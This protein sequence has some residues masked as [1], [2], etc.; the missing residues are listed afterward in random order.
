M[1]FQSLL[2]HFSIALA[3]CSTLPA[4]PGV[5][6]GQTPPESIEA[7]IT[8]VQAL[9]KEGK[10]AAAA[11]LGGSW[12]ARYS[13]RPEANSASGARLWNAIADDYL[14][15]GQRDKCVQ[16]QLRALAIHEKIQ[17]PDHPDTVASLVKLSLTYDVLGLHEKALPLQ[18]RVLTVEE[19]L[20]GLEHSTTA[21]GLRALAF[22]YSA[23][24]QHDKAIPLRQRALAISEKTLGSEHFETAN[25]LERLAISYSFLSQ[26][27]K[28]LPLQLR[29]VAILEKVLGPEHSDTADFLNHLAFTYVA[30]GQYDKVLP[31]HQRALAIREKNHSL[32]HPT[33]S[34][35]LNNLADTYIALVQYDKALPLQLRALATSEKVLGLEHLDTARSLNNLADTY[36]A[37]AQYDKALPLQLR[38]LSIREKI[39]GTEH[40]DTA[41]SLNNLAITY[42]AQAQYDKALPLQLRTQAIYGK[43]LGPS[44]PNTATSLNNLAETYSAL[45]QYEK[46]LPL[47]LHALAINEKALGSEHPDTALILNNLAG[48]YYALAQYEK[49]LPLQL[50]ALAINEK[51]LGP[52][53]PQ[54]AQSLGNLA[55][56]YNALAQ[57]D[58]VLPLQL[59]ALAIVEKVLGPEHPNTA[60]SL[61]NL[62]QTYNALAQYDEALP[63]QLRA[64][65][66][67]EKV[68][69]P[70]HP[71]TAFNWGNLAGIVEAMEHNSAAVSFLKR[72]VN[73]YQRQREQVSII[74]K[75]AL[76]SYTDLVGPNYKALARLL[77]KE[78]RLSEAQQV[79]DMLKE[80]EQFDFVRRNATADPRHTRVGYTATEQKW[81]DRYQQISAQLVAL[82]V[83]ERELA[84]AEKPGLN[85]TQLARQ[86]VLKADLTVARKAFD[87]YIA[88][89]QT[90]FST[91]GAAR[92]VEVAETSVQA[93]RDLQALI[94]SL[95]EGV[96]L[97]QYYVTNNQ[98]NM[99]LTTPGVQKA[100]S[101]KVDTKELN[102]QIAAFGG[103]LRDHKSDPLP[104]AQALYR[105]LLAPV[106]ADL[107]QAGAKVVML[108]LDGA[109]RYLP[110]GALHDGKR[111]AVEKWNLPIYT[112]VVRGK[113]RDAATP[114][115]T[116][117]GLGLTRAVGEF[118]PLSA[119]R[120][121]MGSIVKTSGSTSTG[122]VPGE[123]YLDDAFTASR[124]KD[125]GQRKFELLH[126]AS[127]FRFSPGTEVNSFLVL[128]DGQQL[129]LGDLRTQ[130]YRF[131]HV[132]L[133]TLSACETGLGGGR[134]E[135]GKEIEGFGVI[136]QQQGAKAVLATLWPVADQSTAT[137][138]ADMYRRRQTQGLS[139]IE[140]LRQAQL[141]LMAQPKYVHP[142][143]WAPFV[144]MG[145]WK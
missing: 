38:A 19:K 52:E 90:E 111:Y 126:V 46:A 33:T 143:Y 21:M 116:A 144:L 128:G 91:K 20:L 87:Q 142:F 22:T 119:V 131:D 37:L 1:F 18:L 50:H 13:K 88:D 69:G 121:E 136:A 32:E 3:M 64:L 135:K 71:D 54:T 117:A 129:T 80:D 16:P 103:T 74:G 61:S 53:H 24:A 78:G 110:F 97:L 27:D 49:A 7:T 11:A 6:W 105:L 26:Y 120:A 34:I 75:T 56:T 124:L 10:H 107:A 127:H 15:A 65:A 98:V 39:F 57:Y 59:R 96:V 8:Q 60:Q 72:S 139:K 138:M 130:N 47:Q 41:V 81:M 106:E 86:K 108:S 45:A 9:S 42:Y 112:S 137:L 44:L 70:E 122:V 2:R 100:R 99:L 77:T 73:I 114:Q 79:L 134:D 145:N 29:A 94:R 30:L 55:Q 40:R 23:L 125:V 141:A 68:L 113:L 140:A 66:I 132:D 118:A 123:V 51:A 28:A 67:V 101:A 31:L 25:D 133:L 85:S 62:A 109:L 12:F 43:S 14:D 4:L 5:A 102:R 84:T 92:S 83:E 82:G 76:Q 95:G 35:A 36:R 93:M 104:V 17:G 48:T 115:W 58:E 89:I 63:L